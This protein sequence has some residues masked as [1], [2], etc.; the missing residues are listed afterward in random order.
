MSTSNAGSRIGRV[1]ASMSAEEWRR[2]GWLAFAV[3]MLHVVGFGLL[4]GVVVPRHLS[5]SGTGA[6]I[7]TGVSAGRG[8]IQWSA[9]NPATMANCDQAIRRSLRASA[10]RISS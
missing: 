9:K 3:V 7:F 2:A 1:R 4:F 6:F 10:A 5:V 8:A